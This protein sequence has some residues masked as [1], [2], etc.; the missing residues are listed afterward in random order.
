M[1]AL[2]LCR[3]QT[4]VDFTKLPS[5]ELAQIYTQINHI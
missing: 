1:L 4:L 3:Y 2:R 5:K